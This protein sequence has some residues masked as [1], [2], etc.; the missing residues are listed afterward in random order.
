MT[1]KERKKP[2]GY[3]LVMSVTPSFLILSL[4]IMGFIFYWQN[5][6]L[7]ELMGGEVSLSVR[8]VIDGDQFLANTE[9]GFLVKVRLRAIDAPELD[10]PYGRQAAAHLGELLQA[11]HTDVIGFFYERDHEGRYIADVFTQTSVYA[12]FSYIQAKMLKEGLAW[13]FG[14]FDRRVKLKELMQNASDAKLGLWQ[15][16]DPTPPWRHR[17]A[18][19]RDAERARHQ[20]R[21]P[22]IRT[23]DKSK[24]KS[25]PP[26]KQRR[27]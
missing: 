20:H 27:G 15:D 7:E 23:S 16:D 21:S 5:K 22:R 17:K 8:R 11:P 9:D 26:G 4:G 12:E 13:H 19:E 25:T 10:Q 14:T 1:R 18:Q 24:K 3:D 2:F 6:Q